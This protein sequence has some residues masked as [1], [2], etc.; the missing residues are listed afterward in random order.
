MTE[1]ALSFLGIGIQPPIASWGSLL[2]NAQSSLQRAP[3]MALLP[4]LF[5]MMTVYSFNK[6]GDLIRASMVKEG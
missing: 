1:S 2:Q 5:V 3:H 6:L 4:G